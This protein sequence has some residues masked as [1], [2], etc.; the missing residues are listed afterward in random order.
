M[1]ET[2]PIVI[3]HL[4]VLS[5][6]SAFAAAT[7]IA[8]L[9]AL[10]GLAAT[11]RIRAAI[12]R[13]GRESRRLPAMLEDAVAPAKRVLI[14]GAGARGREVA[15]ALLEHREL[16][17]KIVGF[18][19]DQPDMPAWDG[20]PLLGASDDIAALIER[21]A[22]DEI[23]VAHAPS[24]QEKLVN[25]LVIAGQQERVRVTSA[26]GLRDAMAAGVRLRHIG[27][28]PLVEVN[29]P[30]PGAAYLCAKR[31][32]DIA[33]SLAALILTAPAT[34][35]LALLVKATSRGP[36][37]FC[38]RRVGLRG[39]EFTIYKLRTMI[40]DAERVTGPKLADPYDER[41]TPL[42]R[43]LRV[44]R[45]DELPQFLNVLRGEMSVVGPRPERP[46][47]TSQFID[48]VPGYAQRLTVKPGITGLAQVRGGYDTE[49][50]IKLKYD[51][52]YVYHQSL[53]LDLKILLS[54]V[55]VVLLCAGQ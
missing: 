47:F 42:G 25:R 51:W 45:L 24:W 9:L 29:G 8:C 26:L 19:D 11:A 54:T 16:G 17:C 32:F 15:R 7:T 13:N 20:I 49:V 44:T 52:L 31:A 34:A 1:V 12:G 38:Q 53:W 22:V 2:T 10:L 6:A 50:Y 23:I 4:G 3:W 37:F 55:R 36:A 30:R 21:H 27:P 5:K 14:V 43:I 48:T 28:I 33:F 46:E 40:A 18:V 39:E 35:V 41:V